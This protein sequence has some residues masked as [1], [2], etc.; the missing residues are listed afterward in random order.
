MLE[1]I[2]DVLD[3][4]ERE[5]SQPEMF[6]GDA[7]GYLEAVYQG[8]IKADHTRMKAASIAIEYEKPTLKA[9]A[10]IQGGDFASRLEKAIQRSV[11]GGSSL[12]Q[13]KTI[14]HAPSE[15]RPEPT[16]AD[17]RARFIP[18]RRV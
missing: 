18:R 2:S 4:L 15:L 14:E 11:N 10:I 8:R 17:E 1:T 12:R 9:T 5:R 7:H 13:V 16:S 3:R 6:E